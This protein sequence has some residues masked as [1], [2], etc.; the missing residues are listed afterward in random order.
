[1]ESSNKSLASQSQANNSKVKDSFDTK[2]INFSE[3]FSI[4]P[5]D[6]KVLGFTFFTTR[7]FTVQ[8]DASGENIEC[9]IVSQ[10]DFQKSRDKTEFKSFHEFIKP[11]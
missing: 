11:F 7:A 10:T 1:M 5:G 8:F 4:N 2:S 6:M 3:T 9:Y